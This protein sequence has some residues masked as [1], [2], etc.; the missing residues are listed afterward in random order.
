MHYV[1]ICQLYMWRREK[2]RKKRSNH[3][4]IFCIV[5]ICRSGDG[6]D[7]SSRVATI[8]YSFCA[9]WFNIRLTVQKI[10]LLIFFPRKIDT[11]V[12]FRSIL[13]TISDWKFANK[14][15]IIWRNAFILPLTIWYSRTVIYIGTTK[16]G[17]M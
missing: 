11:F 9:I 16:T 5:V 10:L 2:E 17:K 1:E 3:S 15:K 7:D 13:K 14:I 8:Y 6:D 4:T 12:N